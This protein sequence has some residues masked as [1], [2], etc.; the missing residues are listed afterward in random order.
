[1]TAPAEPRL[2]ELRQDLRLESRSAGSD[3]R[4]TWVIVDAAQHRY[5]ALGETAYQLLSLWRAGAAYDELRAECK[6]GFGHDVSP[7]EIA[8][9]VKFLGEQSL[10]LDSPTGDWR[11]FSGLSD[12]ARHGW[13]M[14]AIHNYLYIKI[15]LV[16]PEPILKRFSP[17]VA[18]LYT[19]AFFAAVVACGISG[20]YLASRQWDAFVT[21]FQH[22]FSL[23][24]AFAYAAALIVVKSL[25]EL[26]HA[27]TAYR[28]GCR[29]PS[30]GLCF[31]VMF[32]VLYTDVTDAWR[33]SSRRKRLQIGIAGVAVELA[34][35]C[36]ATLAWTFLPEGP[37]KSVAFTMATV[38]W[39]LSLAVNLNPLMRFDGYYL[40]ADLIGIENLQSRAF[41]FGSWRL[42]EF[43]FDLG[44]PAPE[45]L[46]PSKQRIL[47]GY[48]WATWLYRLVVFTGIALLVYHMAFKLLGIVLFLIE[49]VYFILRPIWAEI[50]AWRQDGRA[51]LAT[52]RSRISM[53]IAAS[54]FVI[55][56]TPWSTQI[57]VPA[58]LESSEI[59][60]VFPKRSGLVTE[61]RVK[62]GDRVKQGDILI[63]QSS[64]DLEYRLAVARR[65][66][67]LVRVR[68][69]R[70]GADD[71]DRLDSL[72]LSEEQQSLASEIA[73]LEREASELEI[74]APIAGLIAEF[75]SEVHPAR[76]IGRAEFVALIRGPSNLVARGYLRENDVE[77][78]VLGADGVFVPDG[79]GFERAPVRLTSIS[80]AGSGALEI[81]ELASTHGGS[82]AVRPTR[83]AGSQQRLAPVQ[84]VYLATL[85]APGGEAAPLAV[86]G[87]VHLRGTAQSFASEAFRR[88]ASVLVR[89][90]GI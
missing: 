68:M 25:H 57:H 8:D 64:R 79:V 60:R 87:V 38:G 34:I 49:I 36:F 3:G 82:V 26:G 6:S 71:A 50:T 89:E 62:A 40:F 19:R 74:R 86:R 72:V 88:I 83:S 18:P 32:P 78:V 77:R 80:E 85:Q 51:I 10:T 33:L 15:P 11:Y 81:P 1:M 59:A 17:I 20:L 13:L 58:V 12:R 52:R 22:F 16:H 42:R 43:L 41:E 31:L 4:P 67:A 63:V 27:F 54:L 14:W 5:I 39:V 55:A 7:D 90:S 44:R 47:I 75:N 61:V 23:D 70:R 37:A 48:A 46:A 65:R 24:G 84:A 28:F 56:V 29:V 69:A 73:G 45:R 9:L 21:T 53:G 30:M 35:A 66:L 2:P 76:S